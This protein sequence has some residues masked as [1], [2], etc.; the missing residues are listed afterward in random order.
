MKTNRTDVAHIFSPTVIHNNINSSTSSITVVP[1]KHSIEYSD[2]VSSS[3]NGTWESLAKQ[4]TKKI[5]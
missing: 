1:E 3:G 5:I 2:D 4:K